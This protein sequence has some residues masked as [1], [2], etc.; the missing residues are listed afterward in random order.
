MYKN[1]VYLYQG[2][3]RNC[4]DEWTMDTYNNLEES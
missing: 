3:L 2:I 4:K 1:V